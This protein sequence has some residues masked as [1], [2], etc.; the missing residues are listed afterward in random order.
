MGKKWNVLFVFAFILIS[1][2]SMAQDQSA[3]LEKVE[4]EAS[5]PG[6]QAAWNKY[7]T[8]QLM[9]H[10]NDFTTRDVGT[11]TIRFIVDINGET[12]DVQATN[13]KKTKLAKASIEAIENGPRWIPAQQDGKAVNAYRIQPVSL[14]S[15]N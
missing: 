5:F 11:C 8:Q 3:P 12:K 10:V 13:M 1:H 2:H 4:V 9:L 6:G 14:Q 15:G 7:I